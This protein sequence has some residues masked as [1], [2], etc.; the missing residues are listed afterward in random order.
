M[1]HY[2]CPPSFKLPASAHVFSR[3]GET[4]RAHSVNVFETKGR[5]RPR[6]QILLCKKQIAQNLAQKL[7]ARV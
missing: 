3:N 7:E 1:H 4:L 2:L 6:V 5:V